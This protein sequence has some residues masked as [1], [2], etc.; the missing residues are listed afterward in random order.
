MIRDGLKFNTYKLNRHPTYKRHDIL[1]IDN[2]NKT[3]V[4]RGSM[5]LFKDDERFTINQYLS[6]SHL[7]KHNNNFYFID[8]VERDNRYV[9]RKVKYLLKDG[10]SCY[11]VGSSVK[12]LIYYLA[13]ILYYNFSLDFSKQHIE[14]FDFSKANRGYFVVNFVRYKDLTD[15]DYICYHDNKLYFNDDI[16]KV[17]EF[18]TKSGMTTRRILPIKEFLKGGG[19]VC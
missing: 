16:D 5:L 7:L 10:N 2:T 17:N 15:N 4:T 11:V 6:C 9:I 12:E 8:V 3:L 13:S 18:L 1:T 14:K 19:V